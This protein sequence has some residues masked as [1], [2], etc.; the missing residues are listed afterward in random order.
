MLSIAS[1]NGAEARNACILPA[2]RASIIG[3]YCH[4][5][6]GDK[7]GVVLHPTFCKMI[8]CMWLLF[9]AVLCC[10][11]LYCALLCCAALR[12]D[13]MCMMGLPAW[14]SAPLTRRQACNLC[15]AACSDVWYREGRELPGIY[16]TGIMALCATWLAGLQ[17]C[18]LGG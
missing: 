17:A 9:C 14:S 11:S 6:M 1:R 3:D 18:R 10:A 8:I 15:G 2:C 4:E 12:C 13:V 16:H 7:L 5:A